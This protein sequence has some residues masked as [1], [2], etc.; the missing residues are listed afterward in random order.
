MDVVPSSGANNFPEAA[1]PNKSV[2]G[3]HPEAAPV[4][5]LCGF[6][7]AE[8]PH[9][10]VGPPKF[11]QTYKPRMTKLTHDSFESFLT[12]HPESFT[13]NAT[14]SASAPKGLGIE[15]S[16]KSLPTP[17]ALFHEWAKL[18]LSG[19]WVM[20]KYKGGFV[21]CV[22]DLKD[23][24]LVRDMLGATS[25]PRLTSTGEGAVSLR[26]SDSDYGQMARKLGYE[27]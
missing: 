4:G 25:I 1:P 17:Y 15:K 19:E 3:D 27:F 10:K 20:R 7:V 16:G 6:A 23:A 14:A 11:I 24:I 9:F 26:Y 21:I 5:S 12:V 22:S 2:E 13:F 18:S 8:A